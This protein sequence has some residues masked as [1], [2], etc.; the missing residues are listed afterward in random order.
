MES[1]GSKVNIGIA[2]QFTI[3]SEKTVS[4]TRYFYIKVRAGEKTVSGYVPALYTR[5]QIVKTETVKAT[6][7]PKAT[8]APK[9]TETPEPA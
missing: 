3:L 7:T 5:F 6:E 4:G 9:Q 2:K 1:E 8:E